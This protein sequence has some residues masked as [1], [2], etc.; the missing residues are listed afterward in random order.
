[1]CL[2]KLIERKR[3]RQE[4]VTVEQNGQIID[5]GKFKDTLLSEGDKVEFVYYMGGGTA[6]LN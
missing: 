6:W 3:I 5:K 1:M 2:L 4:V